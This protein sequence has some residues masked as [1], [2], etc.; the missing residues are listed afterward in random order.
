MLILVFI[1]CIADLIFSCQKKSKVFKVRFFSLNRPIWLLK[2]LKFYPDLR[3]AGKFQKKCT[4][5]KLDPNNRFSRD[6]K[7]VFYDYLFTCVFSWIFPQTE[8]IIKFRTFRHS[9]WPTREKSFRSL[10]GLFDVQIRNPQPKGLKI[11][12]T[13]YFPLPI[14]KC[15]NNLEF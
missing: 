1:V 2:K 7:R 11:K 9:Y 8:V 5:V 15:G 10:K 12:K 14:E 3:F 4:G 13:S 6:Q